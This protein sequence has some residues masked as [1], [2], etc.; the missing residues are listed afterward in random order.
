MS[1]MQDGLDRGAHSY[2]VY[3]HAKL[4]KHQ[5]V[6]RAAWTRVNQLVER[7]DVVEID[8]GRIVC[9]KGGHPWTHIG[10]RCIQK[11]RRLEMTCTA[12]DA[13]QFITVT[14]RVGTDLF[15]LKELLESTD[16]SAAFHSA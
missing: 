11:G 6:I 1:L 4:G 10:V 14:F 8:L 12:S 15:E 13:L 9:A 2:H 5:T 7:K 3:A 16:L